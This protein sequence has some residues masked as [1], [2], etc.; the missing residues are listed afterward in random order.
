MGLKRR[1]L[2]YMN[3]NVFKAKIILLRKVSASYVFG[4]RGQKIYLL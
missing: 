4:V 3:L 1:A 2:L